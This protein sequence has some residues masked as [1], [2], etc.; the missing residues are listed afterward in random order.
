MKAE[1]GSP[2]AR[3]RMSAH[4]AFDPK[5]QSRQMTRSQAYKWLAQQ[6]GVSERECH[7]LK[8]DIPMCERVISVCCID[9]FKDLI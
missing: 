3:A 9:S 7:M 4:N 5:W 2:L 6:L 8:F 1:P